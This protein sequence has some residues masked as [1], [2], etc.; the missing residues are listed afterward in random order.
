VLYRCMHACRA[1]AH[2]AMQMMVGNTFTVAVTRV[3]YHS[4]LCCMIYAAIF[5][6]SGRLLAQDP[7][8]SVGHQKRFVCRL[9]VAA[10][11]V[12]LY[13]S[14]L[15]MWCWHILRMDSG[16]AD[17]W[18]GRRAWLSQRMVVNQGTA[19]YK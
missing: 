4:R 10:L 2:C 18:A 14:E 3:Y 19:I 13:Y 11:F 8:N 15:F 1:T 12:A 6:A 7:W 16:A 9:L 17:E 5:G